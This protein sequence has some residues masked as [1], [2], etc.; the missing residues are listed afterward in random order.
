MYR[1]AWHFLFDGGA[2]SMIKQACTLAVAA[3]VGLGATDAGAQ[4]FTPTFMSPERSADVGIYVS[5]GPGE[6]S[7]EGIWRRNF[8]AYDLGFRGGLADGDGVVLLVGAELRMPFDIQ[9]V[10]LQTAFVGGLQAGIGDGGA[11][12][13]QGG[14]TFG[15]PIVEPGFRF[16]PYIHP[17]LALVSR[18]GRDD[19]DLDPLVDLGFDFLLPQNLAFRVAFSLGGPTA[20]WG[21]GFAWR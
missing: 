4:V 10:P 6:F 14:A 3:L 5:D 12:G 7:I 8:G 1:A 20:G 13:F 9:D 21:M 2:D 17:R 19:M 16:V 15:Y 18:F 11:A